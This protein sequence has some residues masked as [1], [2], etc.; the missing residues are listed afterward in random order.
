MGTTLYFV[1]GVSHTGAWVNWHHMFDLLEWRLKVSYKLLPQ[2]ASRPSGSM[3]GFCLTPVDARF[4]GS[5]KETEGEVLVTW[6]RDRGCL[7][8]EIHTGDWEDKSS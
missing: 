4:E 5:R 1:N 6:V 2:G 8:Q 7:N 3:I